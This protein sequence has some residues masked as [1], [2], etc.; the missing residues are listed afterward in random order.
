MAKDVDPGGI[1]DGLSNQPRVA[2][3]NLH[4]CIGYQSAGLVMHGS[5][6][7]CRIVLCQHG[8][9]GN[10][11]NK[12][13]EKEKGADKTDPLLQVSG[14]SSGDDGDDNRNLLLHC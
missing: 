3:L 9:A 13:K 8:C 2:V 11:A 7:L 14:V 6:D 5:T 4:F 10:E 12:E 1:G